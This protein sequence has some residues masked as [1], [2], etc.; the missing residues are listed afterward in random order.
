MDSG[1]YLAQHTLALMSISATLLASFDDQICMPDTSQAGPPWTGCAT[2]HRSIICTRF[3]AQLST[4][5]Q[6]NVNVGG[7]RMQQVVSGQQEG[8]HCHCRMVDHPFTRGA[9]ILT[10]MVKEITWS[11]Q[12]RWYRSTF[13]TPRSP[14][15]CGSVCPQLW[16]VMIRHCEDAIAGYQ[17]MGAAVS[18]ADQ[19]YTCIVA[20]D[21]NRHV[22]TGPQL[23]SKLQPRMS[24]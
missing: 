7:K 5:S 24:M 13:L 12:M 2:A 11:S 19:Q 1:L 16:K 20:E 23:R 21:C 22:S 9:D 8:L 17:H 3:T 10:N 6:Q 14:L 15:L 18:H 4:C